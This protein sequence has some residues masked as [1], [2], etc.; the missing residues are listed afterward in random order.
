M[1]AHL[2]L[3]LDVRRIQGVDL[4]HLA[5]ALAGTQLQHHHERVSWRTTRAGRRTLHR[6]LLSLNHMFCAHD[7]PPTLM[8]QISV[9][10]KG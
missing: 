10:A 4:D 1:V 6:M 8:L 5:A 9:R 2:R 3:L 7:E